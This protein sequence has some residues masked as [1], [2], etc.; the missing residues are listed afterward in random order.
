[1]IARPGQIHKRITYYKC[2]EK[3][4]CAVFNVF[5]KQFMLIEKPS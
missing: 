5:K 2:G 4:A 3:I 1:M